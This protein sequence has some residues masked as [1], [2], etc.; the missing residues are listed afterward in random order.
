M[1]TTIGETCECFLSLPTALLYHGYIPPAQC[2]L[3]GQCG[4]GDGM[5]PLICLEER[6]MVPPPISKSDETFQNEGLEF[7]WGSKGIDVKE[8][9]DL[10]ERVCSLGANTC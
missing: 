10:F 1:G 3:G 8:L 6:G 2:R 4:V 7:I 5:S 9:N